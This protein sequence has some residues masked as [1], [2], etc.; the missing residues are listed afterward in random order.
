MEFKMNNKFN[1][2]FK[3]F[4]SKDNYKNDSKELFFEDEV[5]GQE[6]G[7]PGRFYHVIFK[8]YYQTRDDSD[9]NPET[10]YGKKLTPIID[11]TFDFQIKEYDN[12]NQILRDQTQIETED[13][14]LYKSL[15]EYAQNKAIE[16]IAR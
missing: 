6:L 16:N 5:D 14:D 13:P 4:L 11:D 10:G 2:T 3:Q 8:G 12:Q 15:L 7:H 9:L 1:E